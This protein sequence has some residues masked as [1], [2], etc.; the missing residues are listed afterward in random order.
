MPDE[1]AKKRLQKSAIHASF[2]KKKVLGFKL[3]RGSA[4]N[5]SIRR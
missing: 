4:P 2:P 5:D 3:S 1:N